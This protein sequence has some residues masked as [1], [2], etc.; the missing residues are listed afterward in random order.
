MT[1]S[2]HIVV[3]DNNLPRNLRDLALHFMLII[4]QHL[5]NLFTAAYN[6][7]HLKD[8]QVLIANDVNK[9]VFPI[10]ILSFELDFVVLLYD[11]E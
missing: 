11:L 3:G 6:L 9:W 7:L 10:E 8:A 1:I 4:H 5:N 2:R